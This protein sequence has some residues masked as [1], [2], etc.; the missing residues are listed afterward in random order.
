MRQ[1]VLVATTPAKCPSQVSILAAANPC[2]RQAKGRDASAA[3]LGGDAVLLASS[4]NFTVWKS[5]KK[6]ISAGRSSSSIWNLA[7]MYWLHFWDPG[8]QPDC[9]GF[10]SEPGLGLGSAPALAENDGWVFQSGYGRSFSVIL[11]QHPYL[12]TS[13]P[14]LR[15]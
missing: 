11:L 8:E 2:S 15:Q 6:C 3:G 12:A 4:Q 14:T 10:L 9:Q 7:S 13:F 5:D 1:W